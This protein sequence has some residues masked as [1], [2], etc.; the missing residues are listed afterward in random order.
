MR[1]YWIN[2]SILSELGK[3]VQTNLRTCAISTILHFLSLMPRS[4]I[5]RIAEIAHHP[6]ARQCVTFQIAVSPGQQTKTYLTK[7]VVVRIPCKESM[8]PSRFLFAACS[9]SSKLFASISLFA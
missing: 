4:S 7:Y 5:S 9:F 3:E 8:S 1:Y 6:N 2:L